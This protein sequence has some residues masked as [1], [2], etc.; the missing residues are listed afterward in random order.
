MAAQSP[1][2]G[3]SLPDVP[4]TPISL[5][6]TVCLGAYLVA[7]AAILMLAVWQAIP[8]CD[9][10]TVVVDSLSPAQVLTKGGDRLRIAGEGFRKGTTVQIGD[11]PA[12]TATYY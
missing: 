3:A 2:H 10:A 4:P 6:G 9:V 7:L 11:S 12:S 8:S 5:T 1:G